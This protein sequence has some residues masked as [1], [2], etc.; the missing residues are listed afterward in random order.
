MTFIE[1]KLQ[2]ELIE[3]SLILYHALF[4]IVM[5]TRMYGGQLPLTSSSCRG[6]GGPFR[7]PAKWG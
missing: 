7:P 4:H 6:L 5:S 3:I 2:I 1:V